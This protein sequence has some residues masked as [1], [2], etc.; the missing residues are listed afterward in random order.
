M[1]REVTSIERRFFMFV[2][3]IHKIYLTSALCPIKGQPLGIK[4]S[5]QLCK[6]EA[7][8]QPSDSLQPHHPHRINP[9]VYNF[10]SNCSQIHFLGR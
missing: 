10:P 6:L 1:P 8:I 2:F 3:F 4:R 5:T 7:K 9:K